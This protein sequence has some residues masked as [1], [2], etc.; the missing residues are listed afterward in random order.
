M[1]VAALGPKA[2]AVAR[3]QADGAHPYLVTP[4]HTAGAREILGP[5][6]ILAVEQ[7]VVLTEDTETFRRRAHAHL[8]I[9]TGLPN[10]RNSWLRLGFGDDDLVRGGSD[11]LAERIVAHGD[12]AAIAT[13]VQA[14]LDAG[15]DQVCLQV[16]GEGPAD[17]PAGDI[18]RLATALL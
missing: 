13:A 10:Y 14:H 11:R 6:K 15:A 2:L 17:F 9:Y 7:G 4:E 8:E 16:L 12:E 1:V 18:A 3:D 5:G